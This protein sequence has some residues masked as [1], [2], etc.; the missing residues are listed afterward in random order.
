MKKTRLNDL[1]SSLTIGF[2]AYRIAIRKFVLKFLLVV[3]MV[4][5]LLAFLDNMPS[6]LLYILNMYYLYKYMKEQYPEKGVKVKD[7]YQ[8]AES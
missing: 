2:I 1:K 5:F 7:R 6:M 8:V 3:N 4:M